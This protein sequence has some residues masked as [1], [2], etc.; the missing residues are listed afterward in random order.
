MGVYRVTEEVQVPQKLTAI[1]DNHQI[2][3]RLCT[4]NS[5][6]YYGYATEVF[7]P[8]NGDFQGTLL[9]VPNIRERELMEVT[10]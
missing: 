3:F 2:R 9:W 8:L 4:S 6:Y 1:D 7:A 10:K 5:K